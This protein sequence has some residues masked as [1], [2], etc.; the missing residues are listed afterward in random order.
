MNSLFLNRELGWLKFNK[1]VL[2]QAQD[3]RHP[4]L[5]RVRFLNIFHSNFDEF[6]MKRVGSLQRQ[7]YARVA[8]SSLDGLNPEDQLKLIREKVQKLNESAAE[9]LNGRILKELH[10]QGVDLMQFSN[11]SETERNW[12]THFFRDKIF[13]VL[14]PMAVDPGHPFPLISNLSVSLAVSLQNPNDDELL[15]ARIKI[16]DIFPLWLRVPDTPQGVE[17]FVSCISLVK[18]HLADLFPRMNIQNVLTFRVTRNIDIDAAEQEGAEDL[19]E[20]IEEEVRARRFAEV[21]RLEH[22]PNPDPW[23]QHFLTTELDIAGADVYVCPHPLEYKNLSTIAEL[24][25]STLKFK[26]WNPVTLPTL[27]DEPVNIFSLIRSGDIFV[28]HPY[29]SFATSVERFIQTAAQDPAVVAIKMTLY[30]TSEQSPIVHALIRAAEYG[31]QVVCLVELKARLDEERNIYWAQAMERAGVH[32]VYGI[33]GLKTHGKIALVIRREK[34]EFRS[35]VHIGTGNYHPQ[36]AKTYTDMGL[37]TARPEI[38]SEVVELFHYLTGRSLKADYKQL[39]ISPIN[40]KS[41]FLEMIQ[42]EARNAKL[43]LPARIIAKFNNLD[44]RDVIEN[45][46]EAS[47]AGVEITLI[48]RGFSCLRPGLA[49]VSERIKVIS[50][51]GPL[52]EHSRVFYFQNGQ[53]QEIDG[54][55]FIGSADWM[56]RNLVGRVEVVA[57]IFDRPA[58][59]KIWETLQTLIHD[60]RL[61]WDLDSEGNY[62][63]RQP[64]TAE[65][66]LGSQEALMEKTRARSLAMKPSALPE[67]HS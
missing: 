10:S 46:Y 67:G 41:R 27:A 22:D 48:V 18:H 3:E 43:G 55:F 16:P 25:I 31:K 32:V 7:L 62:H 9:T 44:D 36:T 8:T 6:F 58:R 2:A 42:Q 39:L 26:P 23:L 52:L 49:G 20:M 21:V 40:L 5:E 60:Q 19:L 24:N 29:D 14:T 63:Q 61:A 64:Q 17:R 45:L 53:S 56:S 35:Y 65:Q 59:E 38:T 11:L 13:P 54:L 15:F 28:H 12:A 33:M 4:L 66:E 30:R 1:R 50:V 51:I 37:M 34:D 47:R 57:P